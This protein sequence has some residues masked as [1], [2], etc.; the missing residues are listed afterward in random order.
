MVIRM[1]VLHPSYIVTMDKNNRILEDHYIGIENGIIAYLGKEKPSEGDIVE[2][3]KR[4]LI[5]GFINAHTHVAMTILRGLKDDVDLQTWL[6]KYI[7]PLEKLLKPRDVY[8]G[9]LYGIA[10]MLSN[11][12]TCFLDMYYHE[13]EVARAV[14]DAGIRAVL[15]YGSADVFFNRTPDEEF[16]IAEEFRY[17]LQKIA[18]KNPDKVFFAYG[19]HSPYGCTKELLQLFSQA[20]EENNIRIHIHL[21]ETRQEVKAVK[22]ATGKTPIKYL[23][24][25][26]FLSS[27]VMAAHVVWPQDHEYS[28]LSERGV[29]V[30]HNPSSNLKL[31][32][33]ICPITRYIEDGINVALATDGPASNNRLDIWKEMYVAS[34]LQK[35]I[36]LNPEVVP[37][38]E[39]M[40]MAT[41]NGARALGLERYIGSLET[42]KYADFVIVDLNKVLE[43]TPFHDILSMIV[44][45]IDSRSIESVWVAGKKLYDHNEG[46]TTI[47]ID[48]LREK[49]NE[50]R[51][52]LLREAR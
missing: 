20:A 42:G 30:L 46:F 32:S 48:A 25:L 52:R 19:P 28:I 14:V 2:L 27:K 35:G 45:S 21:S 50:I 33:G 29:H 18:E 5:P 17:N 1:I 13:I 36:R 31:A 39:A 24:S 16:K 11:G 51:E 6:N 47:D 22:D 15:S 40:K 12:I 9:A 37:A 4:I 3:P 34:I 7:L 23:D 8:Y 43:S 44:Y 26:G 10:E 49:L 41:I 38:S